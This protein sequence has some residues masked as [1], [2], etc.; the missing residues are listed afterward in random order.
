MIKKNFVQLGAGAGDKDPGSH[1]FD[2][3]TSVVKSADK[4]T[5][6][7]ILLVEPHPANQEALKE[8]WKDYPQVE[9][10]K[11]GIVPS[12]HKE[13][14]V[15]FHYLTGNGPHYGLTSIKKQTD[16]LEQ[17]AQF[18][19]PCETLTE[20]LKR[21]LDKEVID[22]LAIDIEGVDGDIILDTDWSLF[23][24][25]EISFEYVHIKNQ[26]DQVKKHLE[27]HGFK[28]NGNGLDGNNLDWSFKKSEIN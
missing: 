15:T 12:S 16:H 11:I 3:F 7:K 21:T 10:Y 4:E 25:K 6:G 1:F 14:T 22:L 17:H 23:N 8:C 26:L 5:I 24:V 19:A 20:F 13:K 9:T 18:V 2:G 28:F 27:N